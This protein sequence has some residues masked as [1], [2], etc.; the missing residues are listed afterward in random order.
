MI[1]RF[2]GRYEFLSNFSRSKVFYDGYS[3]PSVEHAFQAAKTTDIDI[4]ERMRLLKTPG[5]AK[6]FGREV[7]LRRDW[8]DIKVDVMGQLLQGKFSDFMLARRLVAT[9]NQELVEGNNWHDN[10]WGVC[11]C[12]RCGRRG[13]NHLGVL[14]MIIR[15][16]ILQF[17]DTVSGYRRGDDE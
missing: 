12:S 8:E 13:E 1:D 15:G 11:T 3:Y 4:R 14:L 17:V 7:S 2:S 16:N 10:F 6:R 9:E 5:E